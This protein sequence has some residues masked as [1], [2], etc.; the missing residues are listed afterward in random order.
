MCKIKLKTNGFNQIGLLILTTYSKIDCGSLL[1]ER[2][3]WI[4]RTHICFIQVE[5]IR[6]ALFMRL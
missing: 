4:Y 6:G 2:D 3:V 5:L 1:M